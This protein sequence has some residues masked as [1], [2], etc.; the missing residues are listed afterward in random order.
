MRDRL[1]GFRHSKSGWSTL[2]S[3]SKHDGEI[4]PLVFSEVEVV[5]TNG[6]GWKMGRVG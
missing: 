3:L 1:R 4:L 2:H 5:R 6:Y